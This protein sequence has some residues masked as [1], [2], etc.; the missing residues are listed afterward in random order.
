MYKSHYQFTTSLLF[1]VLILIHSIEAD[2]ILARFVCKTYI[3]KLDKF[4][5]LY[6]YRASNCYLIMEI[7]VVDKTQFLNWY[8][9]DAEPI[10]IALLNKSPTFPLPCIIIRPGLSPFQNNQHP[11]IS[12][13]NCLGTTLCTV[14]NQGLICQTPWINSS[15][16]DTLQFKICG[17]DLRLIPVTFNGTKFFFFFLSKSV[18]PNFKT[19]GP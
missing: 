8:Q 9:G 16:R 18:L 12:L 3:Y 17:W 14:I 4:I 1:N 6:K 10:S 19:S 2:V 11:P 7:I 5:K 13:Q 15:H